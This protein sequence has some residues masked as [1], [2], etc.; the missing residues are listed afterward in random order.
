MA[1]ADRHAPANGP[2]SESRAAAGAGP[3]T[4]VLALPTIAAAIADE[5]AR[6][7]TPGPDPVGNRAD[8]AVAPPPDGPLR[9]LRIQLKPEELG[10]VTVELRL[11]NGQLETHLRASRPE[12]ATLLHRDAAILTDLLKQANYQATVTV[13]PARPADAGGFSGG[14]PPQ[15]QPNFTDGGARPGTGENRQRRAAHPSATGRHDGERMDET[16]RPR[17][18]GVYL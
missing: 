18:G 14:A 4:L 2:A 3:G 11:A 13:G 10:T 16:V 17:D 1:S 9:V 12:T 15:G 7:A 8:P 6:A 5:I